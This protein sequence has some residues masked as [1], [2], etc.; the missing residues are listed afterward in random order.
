MIH[1][2]SWPHLSR[3]G[4]PNT[5]CDKFQCFGGTDQNLVAGFIRQ[6]LNSSDAEH[7][8]D[9]FQ[10]FAAHSDAA[11]EVKRQEKALRQ[12]ELTYDVHAADALLSKDFV[13]TAASDGT[14]RSKSEFL[15]MIGDKSDPLKVLEYGDM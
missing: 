5:A 13:L 8:V 9:R 1:F 11:A 3:V 7:D 2:A 4:T 14:L 6:V 12:A 15:P 10:P